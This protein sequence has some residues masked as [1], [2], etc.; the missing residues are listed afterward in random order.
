[1]WML[2]W[3][4]WRWLGG[5]YSPQRPK[6][7]LGVAAVDGHIGQSGAPPDTVRCVSHVTQSLGFWRSPPLERWLLVA[8]DSPVPHRTRT[9]HCLVRLWPL[10]W[11]LPRTVALSGHYAVDRCAVSCCSAWCTGQSGGTPDSP[12]NYS[13]AASEKPE[14]EEFASVRSWCTGHCPVCHSTV[15]CARPG[16][17]FD[18]FF[19]F[20]FEP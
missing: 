3:L 1:M 19:S 13:E 10:L 2:G 20:L 8:P 14:A 11:L 18:L 5:I 12:V 9:V 4:K 6:L 15:R 17:F 7:P 16:H